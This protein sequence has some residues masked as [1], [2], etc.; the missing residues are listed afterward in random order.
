MPTMKEIEA[1]VH[2]LVDA[3]MPSDDSI[4]AIRREINTS[5]VSIGKTPVGLRIGGGNIRPCTF[6]Q[7]P[8]NLHLQYQ[9]G[10]SSIRINPDEPEV[11]IQV[12]VGR[13]LDNDVTAYDFTID[14]KM[15]LAMAVALLD[16]ISDPYDKA[17]R[18]APTDE[19]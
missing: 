12:G 6:K 1:A 14:R 17:Q 9:T 16:L 5:G 3:A 15:A 13:I 11:R 2:T 18:Y 4:D 8:G 10:P 7:A 19:R